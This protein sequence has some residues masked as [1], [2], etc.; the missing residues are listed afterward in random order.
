MKNNVVAMDKRR[1]KGLLQENTYE[2]VL[3]KHSE[4]SDNMLKN[5]ERN[6]FQYD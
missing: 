4:E 5:F 6:E 3:L 2:S 1:T